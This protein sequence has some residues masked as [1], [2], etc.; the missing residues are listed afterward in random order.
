MNR[1]QVLLTGGAVT[2][3]ALV[4]SVVVAATQAAFTPPTTNVVHIAG[5]IGHKYLFGEAEMLE[6]FGL[7]PSGI[8]NNAES[9][10]RQVSFFDV[11]GYDRDM[12][13]TVEIARSFAD[14]GAVDVYDRARRIISIKRKLNLH[15]NFSLV[16]ETVWMDTPNPYLQGKTF[17]AVM[18]Q[19]I[20]FAD[21]VLDTVLQA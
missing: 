5:R 3:L 11:G 17:R 7:D 12:F 2:A 15:F 21:H 4:P 16:D 20:R 19:D 6:L 14:R 8:V 1:R 9:A 13:D 10:P 18:R